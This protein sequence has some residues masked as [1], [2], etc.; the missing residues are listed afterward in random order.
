MYD[1]LD[2]Q[3]KKYGF[4]AYSVK[5][6]EREEKKL[7]HDFNVINYA[8]DHKMI[9]VTGDGE[10]GRACKANGFPCVL[11]SMDKILERIIVPELKTIENAVT[12]DDLD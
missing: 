9:L 7:G 6:L 11:V 3:L 8:K 12:S 2:V 5:K 4:D 10:V 1:G